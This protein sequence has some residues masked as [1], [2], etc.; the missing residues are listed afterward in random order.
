MCSNLDKSALTVAYERIVPAYRKPL[1]H[2][3]TLIFFLSLE[4]KS[5]DAVGRQ[6][7]IASIETETIGDWPLIAERH[8]YTDADDLKAVGRAADS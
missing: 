8:V 7:A 2:G 5:F 6:S 3:T 1:S 4:P